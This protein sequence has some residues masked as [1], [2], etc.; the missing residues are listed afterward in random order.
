[1]TCFQSVA[2]S[3]Q[4]DLAQYL[5]SAE[6]LDG[7]GS[8]VVWDETL[9]DRRRFHTAVPFGNRIEFMLAGDGFGER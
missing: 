7:A 5:A 9:P 6:R 8:P 1:M 3:E 4:E 2:H